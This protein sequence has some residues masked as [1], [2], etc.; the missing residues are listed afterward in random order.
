[1]G[2]IQQRFEVDQPASAVYDALSAPHDVL[3]KLPGV[4]GATQVSPDLYRVSLGPV[5]AAR[6]VDIQ[7]VRHDALR[8]VEWRTIDGAWSGAVTVEPI[9]PARTA[10]GV[11]ADSAA[12]QNA[13]PSASTIHDALHAFK[14]ALQSREIGISHGAGGA[15]AGQRYTESA[16]RYAS[17]WRSTAHTAFT[18]P[19]EYPLA[20]MRT[21]TRQ[22]DR[23][24]DQMWRG[25]PLARLPQMVPGLPWNPDVEVCEQ[26]DHVRVCIDVPGI[27]ESHLQVEIDESGLTLR[28]ERQDERGTDP[29]RRRSELHYGAFTRRI[30]L[31][32]GVDADGARAILRNGVLE[33][34]IPLHRREPRRVPVQHAS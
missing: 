17:D 20:L 21:F 24:W 27:D 23:L 10:V 28:G 12:D 5:D 2:T 9:G 16:R 32:D 1:M 3:Q 30:P 34:R 14:R 19:T 11:H 33:V 13:S 31:P 26:D 6:V 7:F 18:R 15:H 8:R 29:G 25:T 22:A 4:T